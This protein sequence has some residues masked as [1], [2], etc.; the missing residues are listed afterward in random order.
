MERLSTQRADY[1]RRPADQSRNGEAFPESTLTTPQD[2]ATDYRL[3]LDE[4]L[5]ALRRWAD[6]SEAQLAATNEG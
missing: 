2:I 1:E 3:T 4:K 5:G 6:Q